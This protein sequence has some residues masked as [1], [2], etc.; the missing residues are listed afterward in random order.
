MVIIL[1]IKSII[2]LYKRVK[3]ITK[4]STLGKNLPAFLQHLAAFSC[5]MCISRIAMCSV[6]YWLRYSILLYLIETN[7]VV[8]LIAY[9]QLP[10]QVIPLLYNTLLTHS[11]YNALLTYF[12]YNALLTHSV[13]NALLTHSVYL[14]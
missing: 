5:Q 8:Q 11:V 4:C 1:I 2:R 13:Y 9:L 14:A 3:V 6:W 7:N 12:V 10:R